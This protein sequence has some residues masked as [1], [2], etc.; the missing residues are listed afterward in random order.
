MNIKAVLTVAG[1]Y[2]FKYRWFNLSTCFWKHLS[3]WK[4]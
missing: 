3:F 1:N 2:I 4:Y